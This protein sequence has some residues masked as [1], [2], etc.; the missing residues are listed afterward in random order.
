MQKRSFGVSHFST[1]IVAWASVA[2]PAWS[3]FPSFLS[4]MH[5]KGAIYAFS[6][7]NRRKRGKTDLHRVE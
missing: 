1:I 2:M 3:V 7:L 5:E 4:K 6:Y